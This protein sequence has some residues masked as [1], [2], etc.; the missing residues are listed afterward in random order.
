MSLPVQ[1]VKALAVSGTHNP[2]DVVRA[3]SEGKMQ[4][5]GDGD[6]LVITT[7]KDSPRKRVCDV[8]L[9][10]GNM[11]KAWEIHD[12]QVV[13]WAKE[14]GCS[15]ITGHGRRGWFKTA[16]AHGYD[17]EWAFASMEI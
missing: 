8:F 6:T 15:R 1:I 16:K 13:P 10:A 17:T 14:I 3:I 9:V 2:D 12:N 7:V 11:E 4:A 5:W